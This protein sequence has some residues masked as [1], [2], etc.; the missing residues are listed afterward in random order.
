M[1]QDTES[2]ADILCFK[3][4][5]AIG[6]VEKLYRETVS[7]PPSTCR[8]RILDRKLS[9]DMQKEVTEVPMDRGVER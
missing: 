1:I 7:D 2:S 3:P 8:V 6:N 5:V 4:D 9:T